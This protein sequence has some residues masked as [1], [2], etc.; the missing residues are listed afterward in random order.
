[1]L[2]VVSKCISVYFIGIIEL[3]AAIPTGLAFKLNPI[4]IALFSAAGTITSAYLVLIIG[5]PL[6]KWLLSLRKTSIEKNDNSFRQIWEK[7]GIAGLC[8]ISPL[9]LGAHPGVAIGITLG[10]NKKAIAVWM[11]IS[12]LIWSSF[13]TILGTMGFSIFHK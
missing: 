8:L 6:R 4:L 9:L 2:V 10:G 3:W 1:M 13:F 7:Y 12:C 5:E 11:T